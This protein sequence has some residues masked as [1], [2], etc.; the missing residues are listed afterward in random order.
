MPDEKYIIWLGWCLGSLHV[1]A[2]GIYAVS[3]PADW[4]RA[5]WTATRGLKP[6][7]DASGIRWGLGTI[8]LAM[9]VCM[10]WLTVRLTIKVFGR[11]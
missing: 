1:L 11:S 2:N 5:K 9:G 8:Y 6:D 4:L 10:A 3:R 7:G